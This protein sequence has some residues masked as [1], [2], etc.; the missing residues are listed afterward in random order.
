MERALVV[1]DTEKWQNF[2]H[3]FFAPALDYKVWQAPQLR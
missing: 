2:H 3:L 1:E